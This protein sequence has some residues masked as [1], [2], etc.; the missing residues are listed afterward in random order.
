MRLHGKSIDMLVIDDFP[1]IPAEWYDDPIDQMLV[2][3]GNDPR[4]EAKVNY[5]ALHTSKFWGIRK[6]KY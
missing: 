4:P 1:Q 5:P 2:Y 3:M 6:L